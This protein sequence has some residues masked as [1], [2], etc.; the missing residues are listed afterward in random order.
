MFPAELASQSKSLG[1]DAS[2]RGDGYVVS[3]PFILK[4]VATGLHAFIENRGLLLGK[5]QT[6]GSAV[7]VRCLP[8]C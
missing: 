4:H 6:A 1:L 8:R 7:C 3:A 5:L 2:L